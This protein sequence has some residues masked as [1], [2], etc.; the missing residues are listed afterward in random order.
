MKH[1]AL[2]ESCDRMVRLQRTESL[3]D[4]FHVVYSLGPG[5]DRQLVRL[6]G[7]QAD[8]VQFDVL[9]IKD[10]GGTLQFMATLPSIKVIKTIIEWLIL[11]VQYCC[12]GWL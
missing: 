2:P 7:K 4:Y 12:S 9:P 1:E 5:S 6:G 10:I 3:R 11:V 8:V